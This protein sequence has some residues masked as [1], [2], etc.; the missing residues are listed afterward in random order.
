MLSFSDFEISPDTKSAISKMGYT[1]PT[2][3]QQQAIPLLLEG[4][5]LMVQARTG[6][7]K[8][9]AFGIPAIEKLRKNGLNGVAALVV[10]P[11]RELALQVSEE[12]RKIAKGSRISVVTVYGGVG[13]KKQIDSLSRPDTIFLV[14]TPGRLLD[15]RRQRK[16]DL[17]RIKILIL[18]EAD[19]MLDMGFEPDVRRILRAVPRKRQTS[20]YS[21]TLPHEIRDLA[22]D[23]LT[24]PE[25]VKIGDGQRTT[26]L[27]EQYW[28]R[29]KSFEKMHALLGLL[30]REVP[31]AAI[32]FTRTKQQA[33]RLA[34]D[35]KRERW[36]AVALQ[37]DMSQSARERALRA[38]RNGKARILVATDV[39]A[40]GLDIL[41]V[42]HVI[43]YDV[44]EE[45]EAYVHRVGRTGRAGRT[46]K[47]V[48]FVLPEQDRALMAIESAAGTQ[49]RAYNLANLSTTTPTSNNSR[50]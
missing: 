19:R 27:T 40:R 11:T 18:D 39:A 6:T 20:L 9:A 35:L 34:R 24:D 16:C 8:T 10:T 49:L 41:D 45:A 12:I 38:F 15:L 43:N 33:S 48:T 4:R 1:E 29:V 13:Y 44:P 23:F 5:D 47:S 42:S 22:E 28:I 50:K 7:G 31:E 36:S 21:A 32:V 2:P 26:L 30:E 3:V 46:G 25:T 37:G 14:A 17:S